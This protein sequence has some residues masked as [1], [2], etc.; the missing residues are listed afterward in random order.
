ML[1][2]YCVVF[3]GLVDHLLEQVLSPPPLPPPILSPRGRALPVYVLVCVCGCGCV[4]VCVFRPLLAIPRE[5]RANSVVYSVFT[6]D[7]TTK[8][9]PR[10]N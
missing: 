9:E 4:C 10:A 5:L 3:Q 2:T 1:D 6:G 8:K 7:L